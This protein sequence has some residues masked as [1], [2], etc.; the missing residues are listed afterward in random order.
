MAEKDSERAQEI[1]TDVERWDDAN[2]R[3]NAHYHEMM[4]FI[5]GQQWED[6]EAKLFEDY[7]K[8]TLDS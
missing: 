2:K 4:N 5:M 7:K 8:I 1:R 3:N 6:Q